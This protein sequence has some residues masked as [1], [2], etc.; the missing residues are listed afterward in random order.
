MIDTIVMSIPMGEFK[1][2]DYDKFSPSARGLFE[3]PYYRLGG[4]GY[5]ECFLNPAKGAE[6]APRLTL[7]K[8][9][10]SSGFSIALKIELSLPKLLF[11]NNFDELDDGDFDALVGK[12]CYKLAE[13]GIII[14]PDNLAT[15]TITG[16]HYGK[17]IILTGKASA[18]LIIRMLAKLNISKRLDAGHTDFRNDGQAVRYHTNTYELTF[19]DKVRDLEQAKISEKRAIEQDNKVQLELFSRAELKAIEVLRMECRLNTRKNIKSMLEKC[20]I[21]NRDLTFKDLF[22]K[23]IS[24]AVLMWFWDDF[25]QPD[26]GILLLAER[27]IKATFTRL[28]MTG[29]KEMDILKSC[30]ALYF[31]K[32]HGIRGFRENLASKGNTFARINKTLKDVDL[33]DNY[34]CDCFKAVQFKILE[35]SR[36]KLADYKEFMITSKP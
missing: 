16:I 19:Y 17:N 32:E 36:I 31:V 28:K 23:D 24:R 13:V 1:I 14:T 29:M 12:L 25:I 8:R 9:I 30:G 3:P 34:I 27:D 10:R 15:A 21:R 26:L 5:F 11:G 2:M 20:E 7:S 18:N 6:Y 4:R 22:C 35:F 33:R